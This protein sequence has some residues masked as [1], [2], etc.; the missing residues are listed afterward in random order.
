MTVNDD[1]IK[2]DFQMNASTMLA[3]VMK[4]N[5]PNEVRELKEFV[6]EE[7]YG[8]ILEVLINEEYLSLVYFINKN[9]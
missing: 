3:E 7:N 2:S 4:T 8:T 5:D 9:I 6:G 1:H